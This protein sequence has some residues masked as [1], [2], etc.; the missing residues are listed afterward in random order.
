MKKLDLTTLVNKV[1]NVTM[2]DGSA[3]NINKPTQKQLLLLDSYTNKL[4]K[5][6]STEE[7]L[8]LLNEATTLILNNNQEGVT[9]Q[10]SDFEEMPI[11]IL[12]AIYFGYIDFMKES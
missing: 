5:V 10:A 6:E 8:N 2:M 7:K 12:Y 3:L 4:D 1:W 11:N 9:Y